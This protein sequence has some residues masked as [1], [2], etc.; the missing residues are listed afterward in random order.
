[1]SHHYS[2]IREGGEGINKRGRREKRHRK[3]KNAE[4]TEG[5]LPAGRQGG[6][7]REKSF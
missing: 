2:K 3:K 6:T 1:M 7:Q 5:H 4:N